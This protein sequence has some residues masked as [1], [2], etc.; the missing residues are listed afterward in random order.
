MDV[1]VDIP[2]SKG[3]LTIDLVK[4]LP[5]SRVEILDVQHFMGGAPLLKETTF[6][7]ALQEIDFDLFK[8]TIVGFS[9]QEGHIL[10][11]WASI[12]L[13]VKF[14]QN[15]VWT[16]WADSKET[17]YNQWLLEHVEEW[18]TSPYVNARVS[19]KGCAE[20]TLSARVYMAYARKLLRISKVVSFGEK[21]ALVPI[22]KDVSL[23]P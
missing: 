23:K 19:I 12:L 17:L 14:E 22:S 6:R 11:Q 21:C 13:A 7:K 1:L 8:N 20:V 2:I 16:T 18:D 5:K 4:I 10:P 15:N 3:L 9:N